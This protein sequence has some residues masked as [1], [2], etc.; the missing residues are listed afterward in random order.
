MKTSKAILILF[1][2]LLAS[3]SNDDENTI[4]ASGNIEVTEI[5]VSSKVT[6]EVENIIKDEGELV[7]KGDTVLIINHETLDY[8]LAQ[9][10]AGMEA[11]AAQLKL[12]KEGA[13]QEDIIQAKE[14]LKQAEVNF[15]QAEK[16]KK[17]M[18]DLFESNS[19]TKKQLEDAT[20]R[21]E[22]TLA[23]FNAAKE[24]YKKIQN[25]ARPEEI[26]QAEANLKKQ[27]ATVDLLKKNIND[28][29]VISPRKGY[30]VKKFIDEGETVTMLSSLFKV[31]DLSVAELVIYVSEEKLGKVQLNQKAEIHT[32]TYEDKTYEGYVS[33]ISPEAEFTPKNIQ[34][35]DERTKLVFAVKIKIPNPEFE[36]KAGMPADAII[37]L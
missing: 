2:L 23:Q 14:N 1:F 31:S 10:E 37:N 16:D 15:E 27:K 18:T 32:D 22:V 8:Q 4:K 36:L 20:A 6:G 35:E 11:A 9:A 13:R 17:R 21:Y 28:S 29:Y 5:T 12:L 33:Y 3:C 34:T 7:N 25:I 24:N 19:I 30:I 26:T